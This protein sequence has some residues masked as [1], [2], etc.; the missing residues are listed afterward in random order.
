M[1]TLLLRALEEKSQRLNKNI[2]A[3]LA[4]SKFVAGFRAA[5]DSTKETMME[6]VLLHDRDRRKG[7]ARLKSFL[8]DLNAAT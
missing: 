2:E 3:A 8:A 1:N 5:D 7:T 6:I 4:R